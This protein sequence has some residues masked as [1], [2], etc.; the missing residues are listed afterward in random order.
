MTSADWKKVREFFK[1]VSQHVSKEEK[2]Q[3][4]VELS[5]LDHPDAGRLYWLKVNYLLIQ[6][7]LFIDI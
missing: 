4:E 6:S 7:L 5:Y 1:R 2:E 3:R